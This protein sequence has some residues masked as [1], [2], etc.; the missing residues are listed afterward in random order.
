MNATDRALAHLRLGL[1]IVCFA[2]IVH[3]VVILSG[4]RLVRSDAFARLAT[5]A[6]PGR[7]KLLPRPIPGSALL[8]FSDPAVARG[9]CLFDLSKAPL[10]LQGN[11]DS[12]R[13]LTLSFRTRD[14]AVFFSMTDRAAVRGSLNILVVSPAQLEEIETSSSAE[15]ESAQELRLVAPA[16]QGIVLVEALSALPGEWTRT[17][18]RVQR[19]SCEPEPIDET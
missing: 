8:P 10:R 14:G 1:A 11:P 3:I 13:L 12:D 6:E 2:G 5:L 4:P 18:E 19:I 7:M 15:E 17:E 16:T 9:V